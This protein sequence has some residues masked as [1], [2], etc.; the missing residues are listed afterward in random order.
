METL[1]KDVFF[2]ILSTLDDEDILNISATSTFYW[3]ICTNDLFWKLRAMKKFG[4][5][6]VDYYNN[7][8]WK[9]TYL[10]IVISDLNT[11]A[12][13]FYKYNDTTK[14]YRTHCKND[15]ACALSCAVQRSM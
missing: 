5:N 14:H 13:L 1:P 4:E 9:V 6:I 11:E 12:K 7:G 15:T 2:L 3:K 8:E 10:R